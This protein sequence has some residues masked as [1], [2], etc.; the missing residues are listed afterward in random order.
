MSDAN[1]KRL[2]VA[3]GSVA[4]GLLL[5]IVPRFE[6]TVLHSY[7]DPLGILTACTGHTGRDV[8]PGA[9]YTRAQCESQLVDDL[10]VHN[11]I[12]ERCVH[13]PLEPYE[14]A[15]YASFAFNVGPGRTG[16]KDGFCVLKSG[17]TPTFLRRLNAGDHAGACAAL[18]DW[19]R[20]GPGIPKR[21][22]IERALCEGH[23]EI[24]Q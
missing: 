5:T 12:V 23:T 7:R 24:A 10:I 1:R 4:A 22:A 20:G 6:G 3:V 14:R 8:R 13:V 21:R 11:K 15:A 9:K 19:K 2:A 18:S 16:V 17:A